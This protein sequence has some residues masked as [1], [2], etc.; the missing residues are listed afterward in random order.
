[1]KKK[2]NQH[3]KI[4]IESLITNKERIEPSIYSS[5]QNRS[6]YNANNSVYPE[7]VGR[8]NYLESVSIDNFTNS[9]NKMKRIHGIGDINPQKY[10]EIKKNISK[11]LMD[12]KSIETEKKDVLAKL[13][14]SIIR[15]QYDIPFE[16]RFSINGQ[17]VDE[18]DGTNVLDSFKNNY[19]DFQF[20]DYTGIKNANRS[21]DRQRMNYCLICG[22]AN[23]AMSLYKNKEDEIK[24]LLNQNE[25][26]KFK[27]ESVYKIKT[28][29]LKDKLKEK[30]ELINKREKEF[31]ELN[32][33]KEKEK[34]SRKIKERR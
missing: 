4:L 25:E 1:M 33:E 7:M 13:A 16:I 29:A 28:K 23:H 20:D 31:Q 17:E 19:Q 27:I 6:H 2:Q 30:I 24:N 11:L 32:E 34:G 21:I 15:D 8:G 3:T 26:L 12:I 10:F 22:G 9:L 5:L 14:E 18:F